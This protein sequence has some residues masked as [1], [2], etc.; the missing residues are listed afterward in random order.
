ML[1]S[2]QGG[3]TRGRSAWNCDRHMLAPRVGLRRTLEEQGLGR[4]SSALRWRRLCAWI[5]VRQEV[6]MKP[7][8]GRQ[9]MLRP[10]VSSNVGFGPTNRC[11]AAVTAA[12]VLTMRVQRWSGNNKKKNKVEKYLNKINKCTSQLLPIHRRSIKN[13]LPPKPLSC[14]WE[15]CRERFCH[16]H[17]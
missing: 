9:R 10:V 4:Y 2:A 1:A 12:S 3:R 14:L 15:R 8:I 6:R 11:P 16:V 13:L 17:F 5:A 7:R